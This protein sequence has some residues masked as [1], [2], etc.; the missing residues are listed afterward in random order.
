MTQ[1]TIPLAQGDNFI[2]FPATSPDNF[3]TIFT[4]SGIINDIQENGFTRFNPI[5]QS[6]EPVKYIE[7]IEKGVG[8]DLYVNSPTTLI[9]SGTEY[10]MT[11]DE[12]QSRLL[13]GWNLVGTGY[14][15][16]TPLSWCKILDPYYNVVTQLKPMNAYLIYNNDCIRPI[17]NVESVL[18]VIGAIGTVLFTIYLLKEFKIIG[19]P[20]KG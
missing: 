7:H 19:K 14:N 4:S 16:I 6:M 13:P 12:L 9:Y 15:I 10:T 11:F 1:I 17:F 2:S 3:D 8:Y 5:K 18:Y 20:V